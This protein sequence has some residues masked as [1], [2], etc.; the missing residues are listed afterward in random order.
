MRP[1]AFPV[2]AVT[3]ALALGTVVAVAP[4]YA[5]VKA[6]EDVVNDVLVSGT[7]LTGDP[8]GL[9][10]LDA[11]AIA[12]RETV[13]VV[14]NVADVHAVGE[15]TQTWTTTVAT[16]IRE[17]RRVTAT[18]SAQD[19]CTLTRKNGTD[20][21][22]RGGCRVDADKDRVVFTLDRDLFPASAERLVVLTGAHD[23]G[24][25]WSAFDRVDLFWVRT[26]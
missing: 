8:D 5:G 24:L 6:A 2:A 13:R 3:A 25:A 1:S 10:L 21:S 16:R 17:G 22:D 23:Q 26:A 15:S 9:D 18:W 19:G 14:M 20:V 12:G 11:R 4:A 7:V